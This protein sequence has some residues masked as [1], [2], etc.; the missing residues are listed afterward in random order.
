MPDLRGLRAQAA[1]F[2]ETRDDAT[3]AKRMTDQDTEIAGLKERLDETTA[4]YRLGD[5]PR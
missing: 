1:A 5:A 2:L 3:A 4:E